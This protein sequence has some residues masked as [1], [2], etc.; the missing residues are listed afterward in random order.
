MAA[1]FRA[2]VHSH[3]RVFSTVR[4][5]TVSGPLAALLAV[6]PFVVSAE[7]GDAG[8][9]APVV[10]PGEAGASASV[11]ELPAVVVT[12]S[13]LEDTAPGGRSLDREELAT[14][15][16][17]AGDSARLLRD[18]P[19]VNLHG[20]GG[21]S[22]LPVINGLADDRV[23]VQVDGMDPVAACP[24]HMNSP[25]SYINPSRVSSV[26]VYA[27][28]TPVS[29]GG[30]SI[31]GTIQVESAPPQ[32]AAPGD[33]VLTEGQAGSYYRSNGDAYGYNLGATLAGRNVSLSYD[34]S[35][36]QADNYRAGGDFK[37]AGYG[38]IIMGEWLDGDVV[39]SSAYDRVENR[40]LGV[41]LRS[42]NHLMQLNVGEQKVGFEGF[43]NQRMDMTYNRNRLVNLRYTGQYA[44]GE[45]K[46]RVFD[47]DT[48][49]RMDMGPDRFSYGTGMPMDTQATT[50]GVSVTGDIEIGDADILRMGAEYQGYELDDW[51]PP[52]G[53]VGM[54]APEPFIN[55]NDGTRD[56]L[57][58]FGEW[59]A[60]WAPEWLTL[61]GVRNETVVTD[62]GD[63]H[64]YN[65]WPLWADDA[66]AFNARG[67]RRTDHN[68]DM[69]A[70]ARYTPGATQTYEIGFAR[71]NRSPNLYERYTWT[72][73]PMASLMNNFVGDG[74]SYV[75]DIDLRPETAYTVGVS[76]DWRDARHDRWGVKLS[77][78]FT[79]V[80]DYIDARRCDAV[81]CGGTA[82]ET[83]TTGFVNLQYVNQN[84]R[85]YG[86]D[87]SASLV[88]AD[89]SG[90]GR[91]TARGAVN[92]VRGENRTTGDNLYNIMPLNGRL[93]LVHDL[94]GWSSTAEVLLVTSKTH[95]SQVR[96]EVPTSDYGLLNLRTGYAWKHA[97]VDFSV[98]NVLDRLYSQPLG[99]AYL[100]QG[101]SMAINSI[102]W[103]V[104]VPGPGRSFNASLSLR[105]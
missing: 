13:G 65:D 10:A 31:G 64:G 88:L 63:V 46:A 26:T 75:G 39:G 24:N 97:S 7:S 94:G 20:A 68:W 50:R 83:A 18:I 11:T 99:G 101:A 71:K 70:L 27:G 84:A 19:G 58:V 54:M 17:A 78:Y 49:H 74:N 100:G 93:A 92:Y 67:H 47:Q 105:F 96:N 56:R 40:D 55:I 48:R 29:A 12:S 28:I 1:G 23:R 35:F 76:G 59:Q 22:S 60:Q 51:W 16:A 33:G 3:H 73:Q 57:G 41:A 44:W 103:G 14:P 8:Q 86:A 30:D 42:D 82:N 85:L 32:F 95:V 104:T 77:G 62:A 87:L 102:P 90:V 5:F 2:P 66:A 61:I 80:N 34:Q 69:A 36:A 79:Y 91:F 81:Q 43:P 98:E 21:V 89:V 4:S 25:L 53:D 72:T 15:A 37:P 9:A 52:V 45:L 38:G 6:L